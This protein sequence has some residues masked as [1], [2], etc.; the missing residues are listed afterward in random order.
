MD[1][2]RLRQILTTYFDAGELRTLCFDLGVDYDNLPGGGKADKAREL[3]SYLERRGRLPELVR[4]GRQLRPDVSWEGTPQATR[5]APLSPQS[6]SPERLQAE[7]GSLRRQ[8]AE[9]EANL[10]LIEER[11]S[12][13][14]MA[15]DIPL[16]IVKQEQVQQKKIADLKER[17]TG[18]ET[19]PQQRENQI[20]V[21]GAQVPA[22][23]TMPPED[24]EEPPSPSG[25][26]RDSLRA[27]LEMAQKVLAVYEQQ[28]AGYTT[29]TIPAHLAV[30][31]QEQREKVDRLWAQLAALES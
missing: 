3:I 19:A 26:N 17:L 25:G 22:L 18:L 2:T 12:Q 8:L 30:N 11:K 29:L 13:Y 15:V 23:K 21:S 27:Q 4:I 28:A 20:A 16:Q 1:R 14:V 31:L 5:E 7:I 9:A 6:V 10:R 24:E